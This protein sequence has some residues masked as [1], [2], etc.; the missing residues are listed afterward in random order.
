MQTVI[1]T[2]G[3]G[4]IGTALTKLLTTKGYRVIILS[5][6]K[7]TSAGDVSYALWDVRTSYIDPQAIQAADHIIHLAGAGVAD[8][9]WTEKRKKEIV[10][11]RVESSKLLVKALTGINNNVQTVV[12]AS[13]MGWYGPDTEDKTPFVE[14]DPP[15]RDFLGTAC[16]LWE[17]SIQPV[18]GLG[19]RLVYLRTGI[20]FSTEG[21]AFKEFLKPFKGG[22]AAILASGEQ[23][24]S[25][26]H[27][28]DLCR[29]YLAAIED[30]GMHGQYN[31]CA[32]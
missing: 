6:T 30:H 16:R 2:G 9:R 1:I 18:V 20:V 17:Q 27:I 12:S 8:K 11:S 32:P 13:A 26:I 22:V 15:S 21:G 28:D 7:H 24:I 4:L 31:A 25:W 10:D 3:T 14:S 29:M 19:K 5:R 23:I